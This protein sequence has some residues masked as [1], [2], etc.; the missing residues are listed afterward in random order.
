MSVNKNS[1]IRKKLKPS[2]FVSPS[3]RPTCRF[4]FYSR[5]LRE[6]S[7]NTK[8]KRE[9]LSTEIENLS[10]PW[11]FSLFPAASTRTRYLAVR[12]WNKRNDEE[13][14]RER[15]RDRRNVEFYRNELIRVMNSCIVLIKANV[16]SRNI[17][18]K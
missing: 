14:E 2:P 7:A 17:M 18:V 9:Y 3:M 11:Y 12:F 15:E 4:E 1:E 10:F 5:T 6:Q 8:V 16:I 13:K